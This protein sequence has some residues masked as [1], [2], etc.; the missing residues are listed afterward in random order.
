MIDLDH[1]PVRRLTPAERHRP[2]GRR[3]D[4]RALG[5]LDVHA[6]VHVQEP[7]WTEA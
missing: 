7:A 2:A 5:R 4:G 1:P 6:A 3:V